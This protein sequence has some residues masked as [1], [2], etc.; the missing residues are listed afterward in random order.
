MS[1]TQ[2]NT[3][4]A[5]PLNSIGNILNEELLRRASQHVSS[6]VD[7]AEQLENDL[8]NLPI[9]VSNLDWFQFCN[10]INGISISGTNFEKPLS[11]DQIVLYETKTDENYSRIIV[12]SLNHKIPMLEGESPW[13]TI[14][15]DKQLNSKGL[16]IEHIRN[17]TGLVAF[18]PFSFGKKIVGLSRYDSNIHRFYY[19]GGIRTDISIPNISIDSRLTLRSLNDPLNETDKVL[20][21]NTSSR[22]RTQVEDWNTLKDAI[23]YFQ[24][25]LLQTIDPSY[26]NKLML[27]N[28]ALSFTTN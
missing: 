2:N 1:E 12:S 16:L 21:S 10:N 19:V 26:I 8:F 23:N 11:E 24:G 20:I 7:R 9:R 22:F 18:V 25:V 6:I 17:H 27:L 14:K 15:N 5:L 13:V 28:K 4:N 3:T